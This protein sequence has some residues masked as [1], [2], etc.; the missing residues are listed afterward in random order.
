LPRAPVVRLRPRFREPLIQR[1]HL[2]RLHALGAAGLAGFGAARHA[3]RRASARDAGRCAVRQRRACAAHT[4][5]LAR[6]SHG[7]GGALWAAVCASRAASR[8]RGAQTDRSI[9]ESARCVYSRAPRAHELTPARRR[10]P[11]ALGGA[12][13][14]AE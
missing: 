11:A 4:R 7:S 13:V 1:V 6:A 2:A 12:P 3:A 14:N 10:R 5:Q 9:D 8:E